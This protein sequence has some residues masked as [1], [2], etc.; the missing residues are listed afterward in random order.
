VKPKELLNHINIESTATELERRGRLRWF[1]RKSRVKKCQK[2]KV[3]DKTGRDRKTQIG[4]IRR[5]EID[6]VK[7]KFRQSKLL[8]KKVTW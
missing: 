6:V 5:H 7:F 1:R 8:E 2:L 4:C 3:E